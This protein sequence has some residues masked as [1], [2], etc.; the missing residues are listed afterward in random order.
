MLSGNIHNLTALPYMSDTL[1][2][3]IAQCIEVIE[4]TK[5][6]GKIEIEG[7]NVFVVLSEY[8]TK[9]VEECRPE[10]HNNYTDIQIILAG[11]E[12]IGF[13]HLPMSAIEEDLLAEKDVAFCPDNPDEKFIALSAGDFAIFAPGE[14]HRPGCYRN[15]QVSVVR[16][17]VIKV[18]RN[19]QI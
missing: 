1:K 15:K 3:I 5:Q 6:D 12:C 14:G 7:D 16:K 11:E 8:E 18:H 10:I 2:A 4:K 19:V 13:S 17:A 9:A